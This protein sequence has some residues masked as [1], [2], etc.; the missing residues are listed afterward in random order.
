MDAQTPEN[1][2]LSEQEMDVLL[3]EMLKTQLALGENVTATSQFL[4]FSLSLAN[5]NLETIR[6]QLEKVQE[7]ATEIET[8]D[9]A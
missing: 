1:N 3:Q 9:P 6:S 2:P 5:K 8:Q 4:R 7:L